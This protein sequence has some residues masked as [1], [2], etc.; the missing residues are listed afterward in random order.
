M[1]NNTG[2]VCN[3][4]TVVAF[5]ILILSQFPNTKMAEKRRKEK[6]MSFFLPLAVLSI[7]QTAWLSVMGLRS[8]TTAQS[9]GLQR[10][11]LSREHSVAVKWFC[12]EGRR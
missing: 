12:S 4:P 6:T 9:P 8:L 3:S 10:E 2:I 1:F 7:L 11:L 5:L